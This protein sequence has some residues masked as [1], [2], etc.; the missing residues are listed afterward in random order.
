MDIDEYLNKKKELEGRKELLEKKKTVEKKKTAPKKE[1]VIKRNTEIS[2]VE[3]NS[4]NYSNNPIII[5]I[6]IIQKKICNGYF[7][8]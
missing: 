5:Q 8:D 1:V 2:K 4:P 6:I 7:S 3:P